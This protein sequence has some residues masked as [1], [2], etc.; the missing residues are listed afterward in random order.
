VRNR[1]RARVEAAFEAA[2]YLY[3][4]RGEREPLHGHSW[5]VEA[6]VEVQKLDA[7]GMSVDFVVF[8][9]VLSSL[10]AKLDHRCL[11]EIP[12]FTERTPS[13]ENVAAWFATELSSTAK[14]SG[15]FVSEVRVWE[16]P[17]ASV[18]FLPPVDQDSR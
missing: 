15:G 17:R 13:A 11:N 18:A 6:E 8:Q 4:Y 5:K 12:P 16:G 3:L 1:Y 10:A 2:H 7:E 14:E 9:N